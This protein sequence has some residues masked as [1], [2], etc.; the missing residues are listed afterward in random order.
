MQD[1]CQLSEADLE[2]WRSRF[3]AQLPFRKLKKLVSSVQLNLLYQR[4][5][6]QGLL[7][8]LSSV[9]DFVLS[10][11]NSLWQQIHATTSWNKTLLGSTS[12]CYPRTVPLLAAFQQ[13]VKLIDQLTQKDRLSDIWHRYGVMLEQGFGLRTSGMLC[14]LLVL[15]IRMPLTGNTFM[16]F[17][18]I[19]CMLCRLQCMLYLSWQVSCTCLIHTL[20]CS[21]RTNAAE[22]HSRT[23]LLGLACKTAANAP[24]AACQSKI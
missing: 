13:Q 6:L 23:L 3:A 18:S 22:L 7:S 10:D 16:L 15:C 4:L 11:S 12:Y 5:Q 21:T 17:T 2:K 14:M 9:R 24:A 1:A 8:G 19:T 20:P